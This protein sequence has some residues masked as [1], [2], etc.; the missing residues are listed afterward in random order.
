[1]K[2]II[3]VLIILGMLLVPTSVGADNGIK[4]V[5]QTG[6]GVW[7]ET[8]WIEMYPGETKSTSLEFK[9]ESGNTLEVTFFVT[10]SSGLLS[11]WCYRTFTVAPGETFKD[12][13]VITASGSI[14]PGVHELTWKAESSIVGGPNGHGEVPQNGEDEEEPIDDEPVEEPIEEPIEEEPDEEPIDEPDEEEEEDDVRGRND[15]WLLL[16]VLIASLILWGVILVKRKKSG[17]EKEE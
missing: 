5:D 17:K 3:G 2:K 15:R 16:G 1:M 14:P 4:I 13:I 8:W 6:D 11:C 12:C 9:N 7:I 10:H